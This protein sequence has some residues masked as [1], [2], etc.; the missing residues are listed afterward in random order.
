MNEEP[1]LNS[2]SEYMQ[3][4]VHIGNKINTK[5]M[6]QFIYK[7]RTDKLAIMNISKIDERL[8]IAIK[9]IS[10]YRKED[11]LVVCRRENG[12]DAV[13]SF[14][15]VTGISVIAGRYIPGTLTNTSIEYYRETKL[16]IVVDEMADRV[17]VSEAFKMGIP[18]IALSDTNNKSNNIDLVIPCNNKGVES[19]KLVFKTLGEGLKETSAKHIPI[20]VK[21]HQHSV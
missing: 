4:G 14:S 20:T 18:I 12:W 11:V 15:K 19:L 2:I 5:Y 16:I 6:E 3:A 8:K 10:R 7:I 21:I 9:F 13:E 1:F 17:A